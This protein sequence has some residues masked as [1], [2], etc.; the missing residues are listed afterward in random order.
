MYF[1]RKE[2]LSIKE[3]CLKMKMIAD[4]LACAGSRT[5][6]KDLLQQILNGWSWLSRY[7]Y[8]HHWK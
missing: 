2:S 4:K 1:L 5:S 7:S 8:F 3:Y 6:E